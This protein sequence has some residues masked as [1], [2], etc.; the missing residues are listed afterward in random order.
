MNAI[1]FFS[2]CKQKIVLFFRQDVDMK[3]WLAWVLTVS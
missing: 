2:S 3:L 1:G